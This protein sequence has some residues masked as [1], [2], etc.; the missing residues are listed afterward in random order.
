MHAKL[1]RG[2]L[3]RSPTIFRVLQVWVSCT[4]RVWSGNDKSKLGAV[5]M[6]TDAHAACVTDPAFNAFATRR[7]VRE[8]RNHLIILARLFAI[9]PSL[10]QR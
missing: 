8:P 7:S 9:P 5:V 3:G 4:G 1:L 10:T 6:R 2:G